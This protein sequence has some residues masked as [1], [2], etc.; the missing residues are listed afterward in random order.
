MKV[1]FTFG[2]M[3]H[4]LVSLLN[5]IQL[6]GAIDVVVVI[7]DTG[8][9]TIG[10]GVKQDFLNVSFKI[11]KASE[12]ATWY[13]K[14]FFKGFKNIVQDEKPD[15][16]VAIWPYILGFIFKPGLLTFIKRR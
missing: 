11:I 2:G 9:K 7:P 10:K 15:I 5:R 1:L 16:I 4:Y 8:H 12:Y 3:P 14:A 6:H 13:K